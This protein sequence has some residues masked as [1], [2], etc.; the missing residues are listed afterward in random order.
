MA[1]LLG[2][3]ATLGAACG[4]LPLPSVDL[5]E[6]HLPE[7]DLNPLLR[8]Q[9]RPDGA[10]EIEA[11][12]PF[13]DVRQGPEGLSHAFRPL[14]QY[15]QW[16]EDDG[17][18]LDSTDVI[19]PFWRHESRKNGSRARFWPL[20]WWDTRDDF[21]G[22]RRWTSI[23]FPFFWAG[24]GPADDDGYFAFW[25]LGGRIRGMFGL[26]TYDFAL[27]P[28]F[29]R[30]R[31]DVSEDAVSWTVLLGG[32]WTTGGPRDGSWRAL[33]FY[34]HRL[35]RAPD[36]TLRT[37]QH[38]V[39]WPFFT[40][41][42]DHMDTT[43][44]ER[45]GVWPLYS[46]EDS[47]SWYRT[48][49]LWPFFRWN[50]ERV[51]QDPDF[52]YDLPWPLFRWS[53]VDDSERFRL[54]PIYSRYDAEEVSSRAWM[55]AFVR[56]MRWP[57]REAEPTQRARMVFPFWFSGFDEGDRGRDSHR[58]LWP[59]AHEQRTAAGGLDIGLLSITPARHVPFM[60]PIEESW[61]PLFTLW[62]VQS[63]GEVTETRAAWDLYFHR[64]GPEGE[65][66]SVPFYARRPEGP[67]RSVTRWGW[68]AIT[69]RRDELGLD[70]LAI[71]GIE[72]WRR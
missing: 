66:L 35:W 62:R 18:P 64:I 42:Y 27:W 56:D 71:A 15:K 69:T 23:L 34:R 2:V 59:L 9:H 3:A 32:G 38:T 4:S 46:R 22:G 53:R 29:M 19:A 6:W 1:L 45:T 60:R 10:V 26:H 16:L 5:R 21:P 48:T 8:I 55:L 7:A 68:G 36:G 44:S 51:E 49:V 72:L 30:T 24:D 58:Q 40:W 37:D 52:F 70:S 67:G 12:G 47:D 39:L 13:I 25:P 54:F 17:T 50:R 14:Y 33:P 61:Q 28:L 20:F 43:P 65:S 11:L 41:G 63:D 31:M 57:G